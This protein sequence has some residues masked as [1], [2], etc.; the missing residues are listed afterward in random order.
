MKKTNWIKELPIAINN[1]YGDPFTDIQIMDTYDKMLKIYQIDGIGSVC[2]KAVLSEETI[3]ILRNLP[4]DISKNIFLQYSLTGLDEGGYTWEERIE[5]IK[6]L[7]DI[8][9]HVYIMFRP[10]IHGKNDSIYNIERI[11]KVAKD[12]SGAVLIGGLHNKKKRKKFDVQTKEKIIEICKREGV[13]YYNK[14]SCAAAKHFEKRCWIHDLGNPINLDV[15]KRLGYEFS[16]CDNR[17]I[18]KQATTGDLNFLRLITKSEIYTENLINNYNALS[19]TMEDQRYLECTSTWFSWS[20]NVPCKLRCN[21][22]IIQQIDYLLENRVVGCTPE[23][24]AKEKFFLKKYEDQGWDNISYE[25]ENVEKYIS[26]NNV[27]TVQE[28]YKD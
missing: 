19:I 13:M 18:L 5:T 22:C 25:L 12:M 27:R 2:T 8:F 6:Q 26:Y 17:I 28:C 4:K 21:Y 3:E 23:E 7:Y 10:I 9:G 16:I 14:C 1:A 15:V 24:L 20:N 11:I